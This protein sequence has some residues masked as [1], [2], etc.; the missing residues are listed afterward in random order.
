MSFSGFVLINDREK[1]IH[2]NYNHVK[3]FES[4]IKCVRSK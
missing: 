3:I 2:W 4:D 1:L